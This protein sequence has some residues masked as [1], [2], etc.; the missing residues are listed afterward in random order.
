M[1]IKN[2]NTFHLTGKNVSYV[3][4]IN[5]F[6]D[7][8]H[9]HFGGKLPDR[10]YSGYLSEYDPIRQTTPPGELGL[11]D[12]AQEYPAFGYKDLRVSA[13]SVVNPDGNNIS[14]LTYKEHKIYDGKYAVS[15]MPSLYAGESTVSTL[16]ITLTDEIAGF[17]VILY[18]SIFENSDVITRATKIINKN[19]ADIIITKAMSANLDLPIGEYETIYFAGHWA[20]E[21]NMERMRIK[22]GGKVE[23]S[24]MQGSSG[25]RI[26]P[27]VMVTT[28][29]ATETKGEVYGFSLVYSGDHQTVCSMDEFG[30]LRVNMGINSQDFAWK[31]SQNE[32]FMTPECVMTYSENGFCQMSHNYHDVYNNNICRSKWQKKDRPILINNWEGTYFDFT[33]EKLLAIAK[34]AKEAGIE[35]F[36]L[37]DGWFGKRNN[38]DCSLGDWIVNTEKLPS[39]IEGLAEKVNDLGLMFGLWFEPEMVNPDS[40]LYRAHPDWAISVPNRE[41]AQYRNQYIL[42]LAND[43]VCKYVIDA[44]SNVLAS[45]NISYVKWDMNRYMTDRPCL[46]YS[47]KHV[48]GVYKIMDAITSRFPDVLFEGCASGGGRFDPGILAYS[49]QIWTSDNSEAVQRLKIQY[50]TSFAYPMSTMSAHVTDVPNHQNNRVTSLDFRASVATTGSFGYELDITKMTDE[51]LEIIKE[52]IKRYKKLRTLM[53]TGTFYRLQNPFDENVCAWETVSADKT[54]AV[55][56]A[57]RVLYTYYER[58]ARLKLRGLLSDTMYERAETGERFYGSELMNFGIELKYEEHDFSAENI[59]LKAVK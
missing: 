58:P 35:L 4:Y 46:S 43:E 15:G 52:Q 42:D 49:P 10:D 22:K 33:E 11:T 9:Y 20:K 50:S 36:V 59:T 7:L 37:D 14:R 39:G 25:H 23:I 17:D 47:H 5:E 12:F 57:A 28:P 29:G 40:D 54:E 53:Q 19:N 55:V 45:A 2:G 26:N 38:D 16:E 31:L 18:Y 3:M 51:E 41:P 30:K 21:R 32:E 24:N 34:C 48:L 1:I 44:V 13:Y 56:M 27:F 8:L 6:G